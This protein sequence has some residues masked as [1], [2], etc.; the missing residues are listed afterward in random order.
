[1][2]LTI[3]LFDWR[4]T[5]SKAMLL[6]ENFRTNDGGRQYLERYSNFST[7]HLLWGRFVARVHK[8]EH[9]FDAIGNDCTAV[10][11]GAT[12][13]GKALEI[14]IDNFKTSR[15]VSHPRRLFY[16]P[17]F[18][19]VS[20]VRYAQAS[21]AT[22]PEKCR[23]KTIIKRPHK[24]LILSEMFSC[25]V[26]WQ[27]PAHPLQEHARSCRCI[28]RCAVLKF[29]FL[30]I[31]TYVIWIG[32]SQIDK[33]VHIPQRRHRPQANHSLPQVRRWYWSC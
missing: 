27:I 4:Y 11:C 30:T 33:G 22:N 21:V 29:W 5:L 10:G 28:D 12:S 25:Q 19:L 14:L 18:W 6:L 15:W 1:M 16:W 9:P 20:I 26:P 32:R 24:V 3:D 23:S 8:N 13:K 7:A 17:Y 2:D 31:G